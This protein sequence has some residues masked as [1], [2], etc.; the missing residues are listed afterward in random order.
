[1]GRRALRLMIFLLT[2][3]I[4]SACE[5]PGVIDDFI[6]DKDGAKADSVSEPPNVD[7][8]DF[9]DTTGVVCSVAEAIAMYDADTACVV[10]V[11]GYIVGVVNGTSIKGAVFLPPFTTE[12]N[13]LLAD[14]PCADTV[15]V[16]LPVQ[17]TKGTKARNQLNLVS[18]PHMLGAH[19]VVTARLERY[20]RVA[21]LKQVSS[22]VI[23][24]GPSAD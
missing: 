2:L 5:G 14:L 13:L 21:G 11:G 17:L 1:M 3:W 18:N 24:E 10:T 23:S 4:S 15:S 19:V 20:F 8:G 7:E 16:C 22:F 6:A 9:A 12:S